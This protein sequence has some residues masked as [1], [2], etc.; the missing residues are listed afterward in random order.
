MPSFL[1]SSLL[2]GMMASHSSAALRSSFAQNAVL[3]EFFVE[4]QGAIVAGG[5][6][7]IVAGT[8]E[9]LAR[10]GASV[11]IG[12]INITGAKATAERITTAGGRAI[13]VEFDLADEKSVQQLV[14]RTIAEFGAVHGLHNVGAELSEHNLGRDTTVLE[15]DFDV[16]HRTLDVNLLGYVRTI[17]STVRCGRTP[18]CDPQ[19]LTIAPAGRNV[20]HVGTLNQFGMGSAVRRC[21]R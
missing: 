20:S 13:A 5:A 17:R 8:A 19:V 14:G 6:T 3:F 1:D 7:G 18:R 15:T 12:D 2:P 11:T 16:W 4:P 10:E 9:R 21:P